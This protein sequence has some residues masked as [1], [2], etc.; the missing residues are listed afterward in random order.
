MGKNGKIP[1]TELPNGVTCRVV[2]IQGGQ[3]M[4]D[5]LRVLGI[6]VGRELRKVSSQFMRGPVVLEIGNTQ[7]AV[8]FNMAEKIGVEAKK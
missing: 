2:E 1:L 8:G 7:I 6:G 4:T 5:R 3:G